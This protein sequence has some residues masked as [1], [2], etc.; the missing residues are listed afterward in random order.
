MATKTNDTPASAPPRPPTS[1]RVNKFAAP[2][3]LSSDFGV[4]TQSDYRIQGV[5]GTA[6]VRT[7]LDA[8]GLQKRPEVVFPFQHMERQH[9]ERW[10]MRIEP[11]AAHTVE[12]KPVLGHQWIYM[13]DQ[14]EIVGNQQ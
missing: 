5:V 1:T 10:S 11:V 6:D 8:F 13:R 9:G 2:D 14:P 3:E 4:L 12:S 7:L